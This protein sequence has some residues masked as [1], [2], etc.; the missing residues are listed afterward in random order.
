MWES[1][2]DTKSTDS[3]T[4]GTAN[5][6]IASKDTFLRLL[7]T[8]LQAQNPLNPKDG[9]EFVAQ[10]ATFTQLEQMIGMRQDLQAIREQMQTPEPTEVSTQ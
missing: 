5:A 8:Q 2:A 4:A 1:S 7:V 3:D 6:E 10:L 9:S